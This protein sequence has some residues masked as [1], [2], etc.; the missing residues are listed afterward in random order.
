MVSYDIGYQDNHDLTKYYMSIQPWKNFELVLKFSMDFTYN[1]DPNVVI[2][3]L[4]SL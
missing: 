3:S 1:W 4:Y 2:Y